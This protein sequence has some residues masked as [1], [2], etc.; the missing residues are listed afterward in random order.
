MSNPLQYPYLLNLMDKGARQAM[1]HE[2]TQS[3]MQ[4][5]THAQGFKALKDHVINDF[6]KNKSGA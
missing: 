1:V 2:V 4:L 5:S 3:W 6:F